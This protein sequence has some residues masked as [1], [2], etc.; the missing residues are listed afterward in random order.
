MNDIQEVANPFDKTVGRLLNE[1]WPEDQ[2]SL[3][4]VEDYL[5]GKPRF[6]GKRKITRAERD[7]AF[8]DSALVRN[9]AFERWKDPVYTLA[10]TQYFAQDRIAN[11][12]VILRLALEGPGVI[13]TAARQAGI[14]SRANSQRR[15]DLNQ[16]ASS[17]PDIAELCA[18]LD[19][20]DQAHKDRRFAL[21]TSRDK[22]NDLSP[23]QLLIYASLFAFAELVPQSFL[24]G[25][26]VGPPSEQGAW[27]AINDLLI[28]KLEN[29]T[30]AETR[31]TDG[32]IG[33]SCAR[34][35]IPF[36]FPE[37]S[38]FP[39][40]HETLS[41]FAK[42]LA[43]QMELNAF[44]SQSL[45]AF[46]FDGTIRF[47]RQGN[48]LNIEV[49]SP[50]L[51]SAWARDGEKLEKLHGYWF[52][53]AIDA[54]ARS[55][56]ARQTIGRPE[57]HEGNRLAYIKALRAELQLTEVYGLGKT[58]QAES[59]ADVDLFTALLSLE[60]MSV[61]FQQDFLMAYAQDLEKSGD[62]L[63]ALRR[64]AFNGLVDDMQ[65]CFPLT[66]SD[67]DVKVNRITGW[68]VN[69]AHPKGDPRMAAAVLDL[70][71]S[72]WVGLGKRL[73][74]GGAGLEPELFERPVIKMGQQLLQLPWVVG[75]QNNSSAAINNLRR[76]GARRQERQSETLRIEQRLGALFESRGFRTL[77]NWHP[78]RNGTVDPGEVDLIC[79]RDDIVLVIELKST[80]LRR[81]MRDAWLHQ[82][83]ILR[84][85]GQQLRDKVS[86]IERD[87]SSSDALREN[88]GLSRHPAPFGIHGWIVD[89]SIECDHMRFVDFLK[90]SLE[91]VL[92]ALRD[93]A[94]LLGRLNEIFGEGP[95]GPAQDPSVTDALPTLYPSGFNAARFVAVIEGAAIWG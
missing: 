7:R 95:D 70:W 60:L 73:R 91:E 15:R 44:E 57:N 24:Q 27:D 28:W 49:I 46:S 78:P 25:A 52:N 83:K 87:L 12:A 31:L 13:C 55:E 20:F 30:D 43:C 88:L 62:W 69:E 72:D 56:L 68:T 64:L 22:L 41:A 82:T 11:D 29:A 93:D 75:L 71:T 48:A 4:A 84:R 35:L 59:G 39:P 18:V 5:D 47:V 54:F 34:H 58:V 63:G 94:H 80:Y 1:G 36:L 26:S 10:L 40:R 8:W 90:V 85:A 17:V 79:A 3:R 67:R 76:L 61:F 16:L 14:V 92:I 32:T 53:R 81:S 23:F 89:T 6:S 21:D 74:E 2:A 50:E 45:D 77:L 42:A 65:I 51:N 33:E 38:G 19:I 37:R 9:L 66:W 86:Y